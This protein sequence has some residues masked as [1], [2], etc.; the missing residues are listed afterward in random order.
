MPISSRDVIRI[1]KNHDWCYDYAR[2][3]H[4]YFKH[5]EIRGKISVPHPKKDIV[6]KTIISIFKQAGI[7]H[8]KYL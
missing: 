4:H 7:D 3:D 1:L 5:P 6:L 2:G 8:K